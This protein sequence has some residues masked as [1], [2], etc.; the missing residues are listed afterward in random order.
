MTSTLHNVNITKLNNQT[1]EDVIGLHSGAGPTQ[2]YIENE[3]SVM[4]SNFR[5]GDGHIAIKMMG[6]TS[7]RE[8]C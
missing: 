8:W 3:A 2:Y 4:K 7:R 1:D 5:T 6:C